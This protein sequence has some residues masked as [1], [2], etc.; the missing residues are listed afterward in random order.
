[1]GPSVVQLVAELSAARGRAQDS[2]RRGARIG[3]GT[4]AVGGAING[5]T[6]M[7][8]SYRDAF[9]AACVVEQRSPLPILKIKSWRL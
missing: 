1:M 7:I 8:S 5:D 3:G 4:G 9:D 2:S 6:I